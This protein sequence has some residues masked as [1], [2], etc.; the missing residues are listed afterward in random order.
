MTGRRRKVPSKYNNFGVIE[1]KFKYRRYCPKCNKT[2]TFETHMGSKC[3]E[4][5]NDD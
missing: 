1:K 3:T 2:H 5:K 4:G